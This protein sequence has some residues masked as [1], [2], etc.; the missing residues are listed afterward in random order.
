LVDDDQE[1]K[2]GA[3]EPGHLDAEYGERVIAANRGQPKFFVRQIDEGW[4][5]RGDNRGNSE[6]DQKA[7]AEQYDF[8]E[9][10]LIFG[11]PA[12]RGSRGAEVRGHHTGHGRG[13][14]PGLQESEK[15]E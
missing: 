1:C 15:Y 2:E 13:E 7:N 12:V 5:R 3:G 8:D 6:T 11:L 10:E 4:W 14:I 9:E